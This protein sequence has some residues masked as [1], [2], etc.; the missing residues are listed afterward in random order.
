MHQPE[1][2]RPAIA[3]SG[4]GGSAS[5][6][7]QASMIVRSHCIENGARTLNVLRANGGTEA[8]RSA[9]DMHEPAGVP[10]YGISVLAIVTRP[11]LANVTEM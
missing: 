8:D 11:E 6:G 10:P 1:N 9:R 2:V 7:S 4:R 3:A 5:I